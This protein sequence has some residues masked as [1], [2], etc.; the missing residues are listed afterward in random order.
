MGEAGLHYDGKFLRAA[1]RAQICAWLAGIR[2]LWEERFTERAA[3]AAGGQRKLLRPVYWLGGWQFACLDYYRPPAG[4]RDRCMQAEP[5]PPV[6]A[7]I[8][9]RIEKLAARLYTGRD[10]P[11]G[12]SLN[13]CL[14]NLYGSR[15][16]AGRRVDTARVGEHRDFEPGPVASLSL[17]ERALFQF[18]RRGAPSAPTK[19]VAQRW[20]EDGSLLIFGGDLWKRRLLHRVLRVERCAGCEFDVGVSDFHTRRVNFTFRFVPHE[21]IV[22]FAELTP[23]ART[24]VQ[25]YV[26]ELS[27]SSPFFARSLL[28]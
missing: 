26:A 17:G 21:H 7:R 28:G 15:S 12:W 24:D 9:S 13:T 25:R 2:P 1:E 6:L 3:L 22:P 23:Q 27:R 18:V 20:L 4:V 11:P 19:V 14:V 16:E 8:V 10:V 5:Y